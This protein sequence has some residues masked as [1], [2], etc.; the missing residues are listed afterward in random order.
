MPSGATNSLHASPGA[1]RTSLGHGGRHLLQQTRA[2][3]EIL[4]PS[5]KYTPRWWRRNTTHEGV[6]DIDQYFVVSGLM[7]HETYPVKLKMYTLIALTPC[8]LLRLGD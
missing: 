8:I 3:A 5:N 2:G 1:V 7:A 6:H 4:H